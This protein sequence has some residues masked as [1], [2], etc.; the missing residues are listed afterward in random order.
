MFG[1]DRAWWV[2][3]VILVIVLVVWG[4]G[5]MPEVGSGI[6]RAIREFRAALSGMHDPVADAP[7]RA[8]VP[9]EPATP[10]PAVPTAAPMAGQ[11]AVGA[12]SDGHLVR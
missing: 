9:P 8:E 4:P 6:G 3:P 11:E 7:R 2:I 12:A 10:A 1:L 5:K